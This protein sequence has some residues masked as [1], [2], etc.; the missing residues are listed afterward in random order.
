[1][2]MG[3]K[4]PQLRGD[5]VFILGGGP[6]LLEC[7]DGTIINDYPVIGVN[8]AYTLGDWVDVCWFGDAK[9]YWWNRGGLQT[10]P[11]MKITY[12]RGLKHGNRSVRGQPGVRVV[13]R[14]KG[15]GLDMRPG[16]VS[17]NASSGGSAISLA[18]QM[19]AKTIILV[20]YDMRVVDGKKNWKPH[21]KEDTKLDPYANF[22]RP[23]DKIAKDA[24]R[25]GIRIFNATPGSALTHFPITTVKHWLSKTK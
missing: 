4:I 11:G 14:G 13:G 6:T 9:F 2:A 17:W 22:M 23:F 24:R 1:M 16:M 7:L 18:A 3:V 12:N 21:E 8:L 15:R 5:K 10:F 19:G 20:G 25:L